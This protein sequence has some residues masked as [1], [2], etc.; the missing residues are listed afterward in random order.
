MARRERT[1]TSREPGNLL[2]LH[3]LREK[4]LEAL[5]ILR[6]TLATLEACEHHFHS[7]RRQHYCREQLEVAMLPGTLLLQLDYAENV[8]IPVGPVEEQSWF[9]AT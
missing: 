9:W 3:E 2:R 1:P 4:E 5:K 6:G 8:T 7:V